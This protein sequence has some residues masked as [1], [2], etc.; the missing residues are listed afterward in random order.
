MNKL[1]FEDLSVGQKFGSGSQVV[2][3]TQVKEFAGQF[4]PQP[5]HLS[6]ELARNTIFGGLAAS[7]WHTASM[8]ARLLIDSEFQPAGGIVGLSI[9]ELG[10]E[11]PVRPGDE[12]KVETEILEKRV[13]HSR[14]AY[15]VVKARITTFNQCEDVAQSYVLTFLVLRKAA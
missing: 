15:G 13:S 5:F 4:D 14:P 3:E 9:D 11:N 7:G 2:E 6:D 12:L 8:S 10:W 1:H